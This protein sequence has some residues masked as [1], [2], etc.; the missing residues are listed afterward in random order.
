[1]AKSWN[2]GTTY[3][4]FTVAVH[5]IG[6]PLGLEHSSV[7]STDMS[8][9]YTGTKGGLTADDVAGVRAMYSNGTGRSQDVYDA[10]G[11]ND[12]FA[13]ATPLTSLIDPTTLPALV[14][15]LDVTNP[16]GVDYYGFVAPSTTSGTLQVQVQSQGPS[17]LA[18]TLTVY[19]SDQ[20]TVLD[21]LSG[22]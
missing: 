19:A 12:S 2:I 10:A 14:N 16:G 6:H 18:P 5:E 21:T 4:I 22:A 7:H 9:C 15:N 11:G 1:T 3:D 20:S 17:L 8:G 13:A